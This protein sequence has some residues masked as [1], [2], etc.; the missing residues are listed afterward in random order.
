MVRVTAVK[1]RDTLMPQSGKVIQPGFQPLARI[2]INFCALKGCW[3]RSARI[4][5]SGKPS[6]PTCGYALLRFRTLLTGFSPGDIDEIFSGITGISTDAF[7][8]QSASCGVLR[9]EEGV[10]YS[11]PAVFL[12]DR[13][14]IWKIAGF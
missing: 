2:V 3:G 14:G 11:Y 4:Y 10:R 5:L 8:R 6:P 9:T 7:Y 1:L 13:N 12:K